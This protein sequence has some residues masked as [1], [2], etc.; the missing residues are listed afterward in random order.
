MN[1]QVTDWEKLSPHIYGILL[2]VYWIGKIFK[3]LTLRNVFKNVAHWELSSIA[4]RSGNISSYIQL[5]LIIGSSYVLFIKL[6]QTLN[7]QIL[8]H[9]SWE[10]E[11]VSFLQV[12]S[13]NVFISQSI[14]INLFY[15]CFCLKTPY[16]IYVVDLSTLNSGL[17]AL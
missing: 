11:R 13:H 8:N 12:S 16:L 9:S 10:K 1:R 3:N 7:Q 17:I 2:H 15:V 14:A 6:P 5:I 4:A